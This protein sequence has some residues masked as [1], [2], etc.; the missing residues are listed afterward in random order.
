MNKEQLES[1]HKGSA[2]FLFV[3]LVVSLYAKWQGVSLSETLH[4]WMVFFSFFMM[5]LTVLIS[6]APRAE[7]RTMK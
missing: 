7:K 5:G 4:I 1:V 6:L 2:F 3:V